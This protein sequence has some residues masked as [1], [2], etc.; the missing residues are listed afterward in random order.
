MSENIVLLDYDDVHS[1]Y[2]D[3]AMNKNTQPNAWGSVVDNDGRDLV[4]YNEVLSPDLKYHKEKLPVGERVIIVC[5][6][7]GVTHQNNSAEMV[8]SSLH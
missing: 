2:V 5:F 7:P 3:G 8:C 1:I 6:Y 4:Q